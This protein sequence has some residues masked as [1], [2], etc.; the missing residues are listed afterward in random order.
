MLQSN[1]AI[2]HQGW[3]EIPLQGRKFTWSNM[4]PSPLLEK[5]DWVFTSECWNLTFPSTSLKATDMA[6][7]DQTPCIITVGTNIPKSKIFRFENFW[8]LDEQFPSILSESWVEENHHQDCAKRLTAKFKNL[9]KKLR[10]WQASKTG[11]RTIIANTRVV[12]QL[13]EVLGDYRDLSIE[14]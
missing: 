4:Q 10:E 6:P 9:R 11:L 3:C 1:E 14:E 12:L 2:S 8:L 13:L 7:S 5:I